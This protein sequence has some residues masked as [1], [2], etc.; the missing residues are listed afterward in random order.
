MCIAYAG[1]L[2]RTQESKFLKSV[3]HTRKENNIYPMIKADN[4]SVSIFL[5]KA[6]IKRMRKERK[7]TNHARTTEVYQKIQ[8]RHLERRLPRMEG[9]E[10]EDC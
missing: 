3:Q 8:I 9:F 10:V 1:Q 4:Y 5:S 7:S 6:Y 2:F